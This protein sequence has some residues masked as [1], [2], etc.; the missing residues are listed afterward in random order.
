M[1]EPAVWAEWPLK[2]PCQLCWA[3]KFNG[4]CCSCFFLPCSY[5]LWSFWHPACPEDLHS[6][7]VLQQL[8]RSPRCG[9]IRTSF[10][11][12][13]TPGG[14][15]SLPG[16]LLQLRESIALW[17]SL[18]VGSAL[19]CINQGKT[20]RYLWYFFQCLQDYQVR[21]GQCNVPQDDPAF[22]LCHHK[23]ERQTLT[24][25]VQAKVGK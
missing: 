2:I 21:R 22:G 16:A 5:K 17:I 10:Q 23:G 18:K 6:S 20:G 7:P 19:I 15:L 8:C 14:M 24:L 4:I 3:G 9:S 1:Q 25:G 13:I 12:M 11:F